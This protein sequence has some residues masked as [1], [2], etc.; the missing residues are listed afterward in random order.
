MVYFDQILHTFTFKHSLDTGM[1]NDDEALLSISLKGP[2]ADPESLSEGSK[3][4]NV[5]LYFI[6]FYFL[7]H[8]RME[9]PNITI[10]GPLSARQ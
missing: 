1:Q 2:C 9:E 8:E 10:N 3:F 5:F 4:D 6:F 7:V